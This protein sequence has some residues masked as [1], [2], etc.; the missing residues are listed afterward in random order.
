M[1]FMEMNKLFGNAHYKV[2]NVL[3]NSGESMPLHRA[4]SDAFLII[5]TG[6]GKLIF[7]DNEIELKEGSTIS[8]PANKIHKLE[9]TT[10]FEAY[11]IFSADGEIQFMNNPLSL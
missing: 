7:S 6:A 3:L 1:F 5:N 11:V 10:A 2:M 8:I 4:T 9:V